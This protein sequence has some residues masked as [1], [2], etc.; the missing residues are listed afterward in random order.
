MKKSSIK[1]LS[2]VVSLILI[3]SMLSFEAGS[4]LPQL[5]IQ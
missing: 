4:N 1:L 3:V 2:M 5:V